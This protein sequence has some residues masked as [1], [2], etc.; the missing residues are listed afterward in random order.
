VTDL[1]SPAG[2]R[3]VRWSRSFALGVL[4]ALVVPGTAAAATSGAY[5]FGPKKARPA[6][7]YR[8]E[9]GAGWSAT[10]GFG[11]IRRSDAGSAAGTAVNVS[12]YAHRRRGI[13]DRRLR[14]FI[15]VRRFAWQVRVPNGTYRVTVGVGDGTRAKARNV[16]RAE[17][18]AVVAAFRPGKKRR[19]AIAGR[20]VMVA[21]GHLTIDA[22]GGNNTKLG[23]LRFVPVTGAGPGA[24]APNGGSSD[25]AGGG[26]GTQ[27]GAGTGTGAGP[28]GGGSTRFANA[29]DPG[30]FGVN[31]QYVFG[32][33][34]GLVA[35]HLGQ[36]AGRHIGYVRRDLSWEAVE[37][38]SGGGYA[39]GFYDRLAAAMAKAKLRWLPV[40]MQAPAWAAATPGAANSG[41]AASK[42]SNYLAWVSA[43][44]RRYGRGGSFWAAN[45]SLVAAPITTYEIWNEENATYWWGTATRAPEDY[46]D[47]YLATRGAIRGIDGAAKVIVG[48]IAPT[49]KSAIWPTEFVQRM[50]AHA[51]GLKGNVDGVGFHPYAIDVSY[52]Y[53]LI[54]DFRGDVDQ[55]FGASVPLYIT[56]TG[57]STTDV[58]TAVQA[59]SVGQVARELPRSDC[60]IAQLD[61]F[62][63]VARGSGDTPRNA[64]FALASQL[65]LPTAGGVAL[66]EAV[67]L[68]TGHAAIAPPSLPA[69]ICYP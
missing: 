62:T 15:R 59:A 30:F 38:R 33:D 65:G 26:A 35:R 12:R 48:G 7:G 2:L 54:H 58:S 44:V 56:E 47:L 40:L 9:H 1:S 51:P 10:R 28:A 64:G 45:P 55:T 20:D 21:D 42:M 23:Y 36:I 19:F 66:G 52:V 5:D 68:M 37:P 17:G 63:W 61:I 13:A 22:R 41:P 31:G 18:Q 57:W 3:R 24:R 50:V 53:K 39:W 67:A 11:W 14:T 4:L 25:P 8:A 46:A 29:V 43:V 34:Q 6:H 60:N 49:V 16:I 32:D 69:R 27:P